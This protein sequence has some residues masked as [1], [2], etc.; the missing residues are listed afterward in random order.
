M[1]CSTKKSYTT[2]G[3]SADALFACSGRKLIPGKCISLALT[4]KSLTGSKAMV[5]L[6]NRFGHCA[7]D[8]TIRQ[9]DL[10]I[11]ETLLKTK[12][13]VPSQIIRK[14]NLSA[15]LAWDNFDINIEKPPGANIIHH[16]IVHRNTWLGN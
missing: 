4:M 7:S 9:I 12:T 2:E 10:C 15:G 6:L 14:R 5:F 11:E 1:Q 16:T 8:K 13:L 3:S